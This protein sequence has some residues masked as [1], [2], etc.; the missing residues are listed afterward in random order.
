MK[1][2]A[3]SSATE[4]LASLASMRTLPGGWSIRLNP[5]AE[6]TEYTENNSFTAEE[7]KLNFNCR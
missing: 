1:R 2:T 7:S 4:M 6:I 3:I 5:D